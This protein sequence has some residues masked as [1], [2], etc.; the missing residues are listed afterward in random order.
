M[1]CNTTQLQGLNLPSKLMP[2]H[3]IVRFETADERTVECWVRL[4]TS[5]LSF[6]HLLKYEHRPPLQILPAQTK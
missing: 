2:M 5:I 3:G 4:K 6:L 1:I